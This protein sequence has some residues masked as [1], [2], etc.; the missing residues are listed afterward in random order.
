M[1]ENSLPIRSVLIGENIMKFILQ[2]DERDCGAACLAMI[3][4]HYGLWLPI[5]TCRELSKTGKNGTNLYGLVD[6]ANKKGL[7]SDALSGTP[8]ELMD[9]LSNNEIQFPFVAHTISETQMLHFIVVF[10]FQNGVF[11]IGD[12]AK[13]KVKQSADEFFKH[14]TGYIVTFEQTEQFQGGNYLRNPILQFL[15]LLKGQ[16]SKLAGALLL[17]L[18]VAIIGIA[19]AFVF[20]LV[21]DNFVDTHS[22]SQYETEAEHD[23]Q[24]H[25]DDNTITIVL[26]NVSEAI[27]V[28]RF[29][30]IF[31]S[32][33]ALYFLQA[34][35]Q[36]VR[37]K[38]MIAISKAIDI[39]LTLSYYNHIIGLPVSSVSIRQ[40]GEYISRFTDADAIRQA[41]ST[42]VLTLVLDSFMVLVGGFILFRANKLLF[43]VS[44]VIVALYAIIVF[45]YR[46]PVKESNRAVMENNA[47]LQSYF[48]ESIDGVE[49]IKAAGAEERIS[50][51]TT[52]KFHHFL[53]AK[54]K[55]S[56]ISIS[57]DILTGTVEAVGTI[58][59]L[60]I[61]FSMVIS[62]TITMGELLS[63]YALLSYF[64]E[65]I[66]N[67]IQLQ[68]TIQT[69]FV[70]ADRL[71]DILDLQQ[72]QNNVGTAL[73]NVKQWKM[74]D[75]SFRYG[76]NELILKDISLHINQGEKVAIVGESGCGKS[77]LAK[78]FLRFY[79]PEQGTIEADGISLNDI[80]LDSLRTKIAYVD[81]NTF[82]F[83]DSIR[84]NLLLGN[85]FATDEDIHSV[86]EACQLQ[87]LIDNLPLGLDT[88][89]DENGVNLSGGQRQRLAIAR[90][91]LRKP[92][93]LI[94]DEAT[95]NLD[96]ITE[97]AIRDAIFSFD[98]NLTCL[99]IAHRL[100]TIQQCN[101]IYVMDNGK[102]VEYGTHTEL[103]K[104]GTLYP[105]LWN[106]Q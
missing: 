16:Y 89:L 54:V 48:K 64:T 8:D 95:S 43:C 25:E 11:L 88:P 77:T 96:T 35:I 101:R 79:E 21:T 57:Q 23:E 55:A 58:I 13:G 10:G 33:I 4:A 71:S 34:V 61:S 12:P 30:L 59:V 9:G 7:N 102:I 103:L 82:L 31:I 40:T 99:M 74:A 92:Q 65:P 90:A 27:S 98:S 15:S 72:E 75:V 73:E 24:S 49:T 91:L 60:W 5:S 1:G 47:I 32:V 69:A 83:A 38:L 2:H 53:D 51:T 70:A 20:Q 84:N 29:D 50:N 105:Q 76:N 22:S 14:W 36:Y 106:N 37:G 44:L 41:V 87:G 85:T 104:N 94:L 42:A 26:E 62:H 17:S 3:F 45:C 19:G 81:Q 18:A 86:C 97:S 52:K 100:S 28:S 46:K 80:S 93:L 56:M 78:L 68:P 66:K 6:G 63:F 39:K 67:L